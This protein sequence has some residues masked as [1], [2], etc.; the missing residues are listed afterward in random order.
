MG[1]TR[2]NYRLVDVGTIILF[3]I[4][5]TKLL[6]HPYSMPSERFDVFYCRGLKWPLNEMWPK[7]K[8]WN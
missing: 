5:T 1:S 6:Y 4:V 2:Q 8:N 3:S 7:L